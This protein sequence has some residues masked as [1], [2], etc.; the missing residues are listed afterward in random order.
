MRRA[1]Q[2]R[3]SWAPHQGEPRFWEVF[4]SLAVVI[5]VFVTGYLTTPFRIVAAFLLAF[6]CAC[7]VWRYR[8]WRHR[9]KNQSLIGFEKFSVIAA[10]ALATTLVAGGI[11][12]RGRQDNVPPAVPS[13]TVPSLA[14]NVPPTFSYYELPAGPYQDIDV[15]INNG[16]FVRQLFA[17]RAGVIQ[18]VAVIASRQPSPTNR[19]AT[20]AIGRVRLQLEEVDPANT[21]RAKRYV[22]I[23]LASSGHPPSA[24]G[25]VTEAGPNHENTVFELAPVKVVAG[26]LY[27]FVVTNL[28][29]SWMAFSLHSSGVTDSPLYM[30]GYQ[31]QPDLQERTDRALTGYV[32]NM[33]NCS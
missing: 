4:A 13:S 26:A 11:A 28:C 18:S 15:R 31:P 12:F 1:R 16:G 33:A 3:R 20:D 7:T 19:F 23:A 9:D 32:C 6:L 30:L 5:V 21:E 22:P 8:I 27:A 29:G 24:S 2:I 14:G 25:V 17:A 10:I